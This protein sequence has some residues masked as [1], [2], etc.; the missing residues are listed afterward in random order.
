[1][2]LLN[3]TASLVEALRSIQDARRDM[4]AEPFNGA[5]GEGTG[6]MTPDEKDIN[7]SKLAANSAADTQEQ[8]QSNNSSRKPIIENGTD[9]TRQ[10]E[11]SLENPTIGN[12]IS[13]SQIIDLSKQLKAH[14][15]SPSSL[16]VLLRG[17]RVYVPPPPS[18][19]EPVSCISTK[20]ATLCT[21]L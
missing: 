20:Q 17:A 5:L 12:P 16:D 8:I 7:L 18:K 21:K 6:S 9:T 10:T 13:H 11:P 2:V 15:L 14:N 3:M 1:M 4:K 19:P